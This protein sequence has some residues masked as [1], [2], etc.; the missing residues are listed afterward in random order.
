MILIN[1]KLHQFPLTLTL[2]KSHSVVQVTFTVFSFTDHFS[3]YNL[4]SCWYL[5]LFQF[6][7]IAIYLPLILYTSKAAILIVPKGCSLVLLFK[8]QP[9]EKRK[10]II[11]LLNSFINIFYALWLIFHKFSFKHSVISFCCV[12]YF[13]NVFFKYLSFFLNHFLSLNHYVYTHIQWKSMKL[14]CA[15]HFITN[16]PTHLEAKLIKDELIKL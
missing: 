13:C 15:I 2:K 5:L 1:S 9:L 10:K 12:A 14:H 16:K 8:L 4:Y 3:Y 6:S 11:F 7:P